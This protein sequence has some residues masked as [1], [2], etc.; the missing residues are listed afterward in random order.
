ML[1]L[2]VLVVLVAVVV[3]VGVVLAQRVIRGEESTLS[4]GDSE[5]VRQVEV[6]AELG[7]VSFVA[8]SGPVRV[9]RTIRF[10]L[11]RPEL[12]DRLDGQVLRLEDRWQ[13]PW[14]IGGDVSYR[15]EG[16][17]DT[18][19]RLS[20]GAGALRVEGSDAEVVLRTGA[21][22]VTL[23]R[24]GGSVRATTS[25]GTVNGAGLTCHELDVETSAGA[26]TLAFDAPP[27]RVEART[28][29][30]SI[31]LTVPDQAYDVTA[32]SQAGRV[33][34]DVVNDPATSRRLVAHTSAGAVR[35]RPSELRSRA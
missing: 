23:S 24:V 18:V 11:A 27:E 32:T 16:P 33:E 31:D 30:G 26:V 34:V 29:A 7:A 14:Q 10:A 20:T 8:S 12:V 15:V 3:F 35:I 22:K 5:P 1:A 19:L 2:V 9:R 6:D 4:Y 17:A 28:S 25:T 21:G 13:R